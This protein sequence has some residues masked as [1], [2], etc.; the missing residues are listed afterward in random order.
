M[1]ATQIV[2]ELSVKRLIRKLGSLFLLVSAQPP[3]P[4]CVLTFNVIWSGG[5]FFVP[6]FASLSTT[7]REGG[8]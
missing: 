6:F 8:C 4:T 2:F 5:Y 3:L 7:E 1:F